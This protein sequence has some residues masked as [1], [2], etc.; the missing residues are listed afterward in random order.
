LR[1]YIIMLGTT[2]FTMGST[3]KSRFTVTYDKCLRPIVA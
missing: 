1:T 2:T 3:D